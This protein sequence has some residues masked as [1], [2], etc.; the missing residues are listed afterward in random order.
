M[1]S[2]REVA[3][4]GFPQ[5]ERVG[6]LDRVAVLEAHG[7]VL[8]QQRVVDPEAS[9][10][11]AE[12]RKRQPFLP[13]DAVVKHGVTLHEGAA[14]RILTRHAHG[15]SL[16]EQRAEGKQLAETPIDLAGAAHVDALLEHRVKFRM[17]GEPGG[18]VVVRITDVLDARHIDT[19]RLGL[20]RQ[21]VVVGRGARRDDRDRPGLRGM[22]LGEGDL[23]AVLKVALRGFELF[24]S[25]VAA[26]NE[27]FGVER[28]HRALGLDE[29]VHEGLRHRGV[30]ALVVAAAAV[31]DEVNDDVSFELLAVRECELG[32]AHDGLGVVAVH[33]EDWRL[34]GFG[35]VGRVDRRSA[36]AGGRREAHLV[37]DDDVNRAARAV[38]T[39]HAQL[40]G[41]EHDALAGHGRVAVHEHREGAEGRVI[42]AI[43]LRPHNALEHAVDGLEVRGV[44]REIDL[45]LLAIRRSEVALGAEVVLDVARALH[46]L[47]V[48][49]ALELAED[50]AVGFSGDVREHVQAA[51]VGHADRDLVKAM[52][53]SALQDLVKQRN[54]TLAT[55]EAEALLADVFGLQEGLERLGLVELAENTHLLVVCRLL[56]GL[57]QPLLKPFALFGFLNVHE[58]DADGAAVRVTQ[59]AKHFAQQH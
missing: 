17:H 12:V 28:A 30:V 42:L 33:V 5:H 14:A 2:A 1:S 43:L 18:R 10:R 54:H 35:H 36:V 34:D 53:G 21:V 15:G 11:V 4:L 37:V 8:A 45:E 31:A 3:E 55:F 48:L 20:T 40:K 56:V 49:R 24:F 6:P 57:L 23:E 25:D 27:C 41:F 38:A 46:R 26:A 9:L 50:L 58:L 22:G 44:R 39:Q 16:H 7:G 59:H 52:V 13:V 19:R 51:A 47:G 32:H 29:V